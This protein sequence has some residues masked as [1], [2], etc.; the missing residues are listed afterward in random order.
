MELWDALARCGPAGREALLAQHWLGAATDDDPAAT[1]LG[2]RQAAILRGFSAAFGTR[3]PCIDDCPACGSRITADISVE[4]LLAAQ[5]AA[6]ESRGRLELDGWQVGYRLPT[7]ADLSAAAQQGD[8]DSAAAALTAATIT[9]LRQGDAAARPEDLPQEVAEA[10]AELIET[11]DPLAAA[12][13]GVSCPD[14]GHHWVS[15]L[16]AAALFQAR[17]ESWARRT[18]WEVHHLAM[19]YGWRESDI[20]AMAP[21]R[22]EA[23]LMLDVP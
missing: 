9:S 19:R 5:A 6:P 1:P 2:T 23:Y 12:E 8:E 10:L 3:L 11:E 13:I 21:Q 22:R 20:L 15:G 18:L 4:D 7:V 16:D 17:L 14:C